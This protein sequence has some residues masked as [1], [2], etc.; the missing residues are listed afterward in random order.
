MKLKKSQKKATPPKA[1]RSKERND[2]LKVIESLD[3]MMAER[4]SPDRPKSKDT[5]LDLE[6]VS[7]LNVAYSAT[8]RYY[9]FV[10]ESGKRDERAQKMISRLWQKAGTRVRKYDPVL[11][12]GLRADNRFWQSEATWKTDTIHKVWP[13]L[14]SI[15]TSA[16]MMSPPPGSFQHKT[17]FSAS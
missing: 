8:L 16:N 15:R 13:H 4:A 14:N 7:A 12:G 3:E 10:L 1:T 6:T 5:I 2:W 17:L 9:K 11:A